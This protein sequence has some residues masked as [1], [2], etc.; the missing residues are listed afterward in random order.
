MEKWIL[1]LTI[2]TVTIQIQILQTI[3]IGDKKKNSWKFKFAHDENI[4]CS[5]KT[6]NFLNT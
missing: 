2:V 3:I 1:S 6:L 4:I 5:R